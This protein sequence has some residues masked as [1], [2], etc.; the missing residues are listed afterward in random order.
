[1][2]QVTWTLS[3]RR[4]LV[5]IIVESTDHWQDPLCSACT[6]TNPVH[7]PPVT[8]LLTICHTPTRCTFT[9]RGRETGEGEM[10]ISDSSQTGE[11][12]FKQQAGGFMVL[13]GRLYG[14]YCGAVGLAFIGSRVKDTPSRT[15]Q[16][17]SSYNARAYE[18]ERVGRWGAY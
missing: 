6:C 16:S 9:W 15:N 5:T 1:M 14:A 8:V 10:Q 11:L 13:E 3:V 18:Q 17:W 2:F 4:W 12:T 7:T